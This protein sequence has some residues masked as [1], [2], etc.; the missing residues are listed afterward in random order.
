MSRP[1]WLPQSHLENRV[2]PKE[3]RVYL[4]PVFN[5]N[6]RYSKIDGVS[7]NFER[8]GLLGLPSS[9]DSFLD[10]RLRYFDSEVSN[11]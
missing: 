1:H 9:I 11:D 4:I 6:G 10:K 7:L 8:N 3:Q 5:L 2:I